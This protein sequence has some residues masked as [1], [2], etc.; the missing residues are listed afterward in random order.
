MARSTL[1]GYIA[2]APYK[3]MLLLRTTSG[4]QFPTVVDTGFSGQLLIDTWAVR[5]LGVEMSGESWPVTLAGGIPVRGQLGSLTI[6]WFGLNRH[7][8]V[9]VIEGRLRDAPA[10]IPPEPEILLGTTLMKPGLLE[11]D[12]LEETVKLTR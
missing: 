7:V 3:P 1:V 2:L 11:I 10:V 6:E 4:T 8:G 12:F 5:R 9:I